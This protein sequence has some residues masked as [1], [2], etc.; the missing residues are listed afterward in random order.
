MAQEQTLSGR[1]A[2]VTGGAGGLGRAIATRLEEAG[3]AI[4]IIDHGASLANA[5]VPSDWHIED[6]DLSRLDCQDRMRGIASVLGLVDIVVA[7]A[8]VVPPWRGM[9]ALD[10]DEWQTVMA[11]NV[12]GVAATLGAFAGAL[13][14]TGRGSAVVMAS[15]NGYKAHPKQVLYTASKHAAIGIMRAAAQDMGPAGTR[16]NALAPGPIMTDALLA[17]IARRH[18]AGGPAPEDALAALAKETALGKLATI[19][20]VASTA[21]FLASDASAGLTGLVVP[22]DGG[23]A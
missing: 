20:Q 22:V 23:L 15:L 19:D 11:I 14:Q 13:A 16:V 5:E 12:W 4:T 10:A 3:A 17:R 6:V 1:R 18:A 9:D 7:N 8:G 21:Y 2:V